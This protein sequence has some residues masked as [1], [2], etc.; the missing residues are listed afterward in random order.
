[1]K[2]AKVE[3]LPIPELSETECERNEMLM[4]LVLW[5]E[6]M[7]P[8]WMK[9]G[10]NVYEKDGATV[11]WLKER[12]AHFVFVG[13]LLTLEL[14]DGEGLKAVC[15]EGMNLEHAQLLIANAVD[16]VAER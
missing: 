3:D 16:Q 10:A 12:K 4:R 8:E 5:M 9:R 11:L 1:M 2:M 7:R 15:V 14:H 6:G 13:S